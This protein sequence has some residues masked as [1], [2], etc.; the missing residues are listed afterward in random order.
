MN[1]ISLECS[2]SFWGYRLGC[3]FMQLL[4]IVS[5]LAQDCSTPKN[6][7]AANQKYYMA[8][9]IAPFPV[10][11]NNLQGH[12]PVA[13]SLSNAISWTIVHINWQW[14]W[15]VCDSWDTM[16]RFD[17]SW[18]SANRV[19]SSSS[20]NVAVQQKLVDAPNRINSSASAR[21]WHK[22]LNSKHAHTTEVK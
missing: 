3:R 16:Q 2:Q 10:T 13:S 5:K 21:P 19:E 1:L 4:N 12:P 6:V 9:R 20:A 22:T 14:L 15:P 7:T 18:C 17:K 8:Y 11:F